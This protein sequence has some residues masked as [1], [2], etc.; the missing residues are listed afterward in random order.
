MQLSQ[1]VDASLEVASAFR[2]ACEAFAHRE[3]RRRPLVSKHDPTIRFTNSTISVLKP[4]L[5]APVVDKKFLLQ[6]AMR[7]R[8]L[9]HYR[10]TG[11]VSPFGCYFVALGTL[12][13]ASAGQSSLELAEHFLTRGV[14]VP[15]ERLRLRVSS[16]DEDLMALATG[17]SVEVEIDGYEKRRYRHSFGNPGLA[18]RNINLAVLVGT[19]LRDVGNL[20]AIEQDQ[21]VRGVELAFGINNLITCRDQLDHPLLA[22][23]GVA[24]HHRGFRSLMAADALSS[25]IALALDGLL[26]SSRGRGGRFRELVGIVK[27]LAPNDQAL[28]AAIVDGLDAECEIRQRIS[29][30]SDEG[31][32]LEPGAAAAVL[33]KELA[34]E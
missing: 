12:V 23:T 17:A 9:D 6:P 33:H 19:E 20:I 8:N 22:S 14:G 16:E 10:R 26:P 34:R 25:S 4:Y 29:P 5:D 18:G 15:P 1:V 28:G 7:L 2:T 11:E 21:V 31:E 13:P 24:A 32:D 30:P 3:E 27:A